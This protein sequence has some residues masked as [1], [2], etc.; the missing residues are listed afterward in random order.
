[1]TDEILEQIRSAMEHVPSAEER[2]E[3]KIDALVREMDE[4][5]AL[6]ANAETVDLIEAQ[7]I[8]IGR[9]ATRSQLI[10]S[11]LLARKPSGLRIVKNG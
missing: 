1:M 7:R 6:A 4:L 3:M 8:G 11:L 10:L 9:I 2:V 5:C